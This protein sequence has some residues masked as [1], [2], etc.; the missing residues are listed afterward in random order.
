MVV[1]VT[2]QWLEGADAALGLPQYETAGAAGADVRANFSDQNP[3]DI[4]P[5]ARVLIPTG[6]AIAVPYGFEVQLRPRSGL[7]LKKGITLVNSPG[8]V[9]SDYRGPMGV[10][11]INHGAEVFTVSHGDRI[12]QMVVA[13]VVQAEFAMATELP[14]TDRGAGGFGSTGVR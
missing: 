9:D 13:R 3:V 8:T 1:S 4:A 7:A 5:G 11:L 6:L 2:F 12:A 10:I 14:S